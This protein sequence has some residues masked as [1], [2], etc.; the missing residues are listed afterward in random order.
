MISPQIFSILAII[1]AVAAAGVAVGYNPTTTT[2]ITKT[3]TITEEFNWRN[4]TAFWKF[5][6]DNY[7]HE[8]ELDQNFTDLITYDE[9]I[10]KEIGKINSKIKNEVQTGGSVPTEG[11]TTSTAK[12]YLTLEMDK[13]EYVKGNTLL[14]TGQVVIA[15]QP[16]L[17]QFLLPDRSTF[18]L[19]VPTATIIDG[20]WMANYTIRLDDAVGT[21]QV[22]ATQQTADRTKSL[23]FTVE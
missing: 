16:V 21:W 10:T 6:N 19:G 9:T 11:Q 13:T 3:V 15:T 4:N 2:T 8:G 7:Y 1:I 20:M 17:I 23:Q 14:F 18:Q 5:I 12:K 22:Y